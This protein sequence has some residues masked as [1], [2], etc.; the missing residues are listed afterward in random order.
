MQCLLLALIA[1]GCLP[2]DAQ[3]GH[4][5]PA[6]QLNFF[7]NHVRPRLVKHCYECHSEEGGKS[8]GGLFLDT[9]EGMREGGSSGGVSAGPPEVPNIL[10]QRMGARSQRAQLDFV[11]WL[12]QDKLKRVRKS[13]QVEGMI[14]SMELAF[15]MQS[16]MPELLDYTAE[17]PQTLEAYGIKGGSSTEKFGKNCLLA[18]RMVESG[19]R[20]V[21][22]V[23]GG[24]G[25]H[26]KLK[27][28]M[29]RSCGETD[30]PIAALLQDLKQ[31]DLLKDTL[32][33]WGG[34]F[35]RTPDSRGSNDGRGHNN[36]GYT[37]WMAAGGVKGGLSYGE[38]DDYG[39]DAV[40]DKMHIHDWHATIMHLMGLDHEKLTYRH[41]GRDFRLTDV[42]GHVAKDIL[43]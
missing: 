37:T 17:T 7:E 28:E 32:V 5:I 12:N 21:E 33:I 10:N 38:T 2:A 35:G 1:I 34:E 31:R 30:Q 27:S 25:H 22:V 9:M 39:Y 40:A 20:F 19:V 16:I 18:R 43:A 24:W 36:K 41:A 15:R 42:H 23:H 13:A 4:K 3:S 29:E 26:Q 14:Q 11:Q 6:G 8:K